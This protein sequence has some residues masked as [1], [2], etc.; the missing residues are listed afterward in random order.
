MHCQYIRHIIEQL[1]LL[2]CITYATHHTLFSR[3][4]IH[5]FLYVCYTTMVLCEWLGAKAAT[6]Q[7]VPQPCTADQNLNACATTSRLTT[8]LYCTVIQI[9]LF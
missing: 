3:Q 4:H 8:V 5:L 2:G 7:E 9:T 6:I 1:T